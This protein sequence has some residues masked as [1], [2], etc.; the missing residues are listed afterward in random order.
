MEKELETG[1][2]AS[3]W[4]WWPCFIGGLATPFL[5]EFLAHYL[6]RYAAAGIALFAMWIIVG[7]V[8]AISP[9]GRTWNFLRWSGGGAL[10]SIVAG[11]AAFILHW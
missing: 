6:P 2:G 3:M 7:F 11:A 10:G 4:R 5:A 1:A 9:P 8:F